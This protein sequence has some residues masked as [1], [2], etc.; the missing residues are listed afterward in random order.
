MVFVTTGTCKSF[1]RLIKHLDDI[2][3]KLREKVIA[4]I[5]HSFYVPQHIDFEKF[6]PSLKEFISESRLVISHGG[7]SAV[8]IIEARK[9]CILVPRQKKF[10]EHFDDHQVE[11]AELL[12]RKCGV[13]FFTD[14]DNLTAEVIMNHND[15]PRYDGRNISLFKNKIQEII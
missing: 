11:F 12:H 6:Y 4:Q 3:P 7:F 10:D 13:P 5:G 14:I 1:H 2:A 9:P 8:E 15:L